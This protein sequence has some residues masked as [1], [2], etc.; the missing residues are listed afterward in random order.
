MVANQQHE[1]KCYPKPAVVCVKVVG[2]IFLKILRAH[3]EGINHDHMSVLGSKK[4][5]NS[6]IVHI[7]SKLLNQK[8]P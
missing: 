3:V 2:S 8:G 6:Y 7:K 4:T 5:G 1:V